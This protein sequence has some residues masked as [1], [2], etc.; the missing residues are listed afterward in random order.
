MAALRERL[1]IHAHEIKL[2]EWELLLERKTLWQT[3]RTTAWGLRFVKNCL[4]KVKR[5]SQL[6]GN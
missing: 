6:K 3:L 5:E 4:A 1:A 2:D